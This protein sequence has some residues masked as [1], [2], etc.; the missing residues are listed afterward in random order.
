MENGAM[1]NG[2]M[3]IRIGT[4][5]GYL[6]PPCVEDA[7]NLSAYAGDYDVAKMTAS[8]PSP[9]PVLAAE[10]WILTVRAGWGLRPNYAFTFELDGACAGGAGVFKRNA[11]SEWEIGYWIGKPWWG[12]G[13][14]TEAARAAV[15]FARRELGAKRLVAAHAADNPASGK[16][17]TK[18]GFTYTGEEGAHFSLAR[19]GPSDCVG[20]V[21]DG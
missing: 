21:L 8:I 5:R 14:A 11:T 18:L 4:G 2:A 6:R 12:A 13:Y 9:Y 7:A 1:E 10:M 15:G 20:M 17:L 19:G 16:V 3:D